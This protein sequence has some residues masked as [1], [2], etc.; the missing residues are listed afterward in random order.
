VLV[1]GPPSGPPSQEA[2]SL[3]LQAIGRPSMSDGTVTAW[4]GIQRDLHAGGGRPQAISAS[5]ILPSRS[6][7]RCSV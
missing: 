2:Y 4:Y 5:A 7:L 3:F 1:V 6:R